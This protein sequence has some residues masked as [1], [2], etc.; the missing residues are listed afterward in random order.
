MPPMIDWREEYAASLK[1]VELNNPVNLDLVQTCP[2]QLLL[3]FGIFLETAITNVIPPGSQMADRIAALHAEIE[4]IHA[5]T[6]RQQAP[7]SSSKQKNTKAPVDP[8]SEE[9]LGVAQLRLD[10]AEALRSKGVAETRL[11]T[12]EEELDKLRTRTRADSKSLRTLE[13]EKGSLTRKLKD[14]DHELREKRKLLEVRCPRR[15]IGRP[16]DGY[17]LADS[18]FYPFRKSKTR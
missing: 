9:D 1:D 14:K 5:S 6:P 17:T 18:F 11:R 10:L 4:S 12:A 13:S 8:A 15:W 2:S 7:V 3:S 16:L